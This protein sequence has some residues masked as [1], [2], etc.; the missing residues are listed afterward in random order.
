MENLIEAKNLYYYLTK[1]FYA[2]F[3]VSL[4]IKKGEKIVLLGDNDSGKTSL[5]RLILGREVPTKGTLFLDGKEPRKVDFK[6]A[7]NALFITS[8]GVFFENKI[9]ILHLQK[10][11]I[12]WNTPFLLKRIPKQAG[13][14]VNA[15]RSQKP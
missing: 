5:L 8:E 15:N 6:S 7:F 12:L 3:D 9:V 10:Q 11:S 4:E 14:V 1:D 13:I 2:L